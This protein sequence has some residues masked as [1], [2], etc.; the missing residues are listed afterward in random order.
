MN[1]EL[2]ENMLKYYLVKK[3]LLTLVKKVPHRLLL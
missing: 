1:K 2:Y 3:Y